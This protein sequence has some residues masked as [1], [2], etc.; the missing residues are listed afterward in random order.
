MSR[1][2]TLQTV[3]FAPPPPVE[4]PPLSFLPKT[5]SI[6]LAAYLRAVDRA[7]TVDPPAYTDH[8]LQLQIVGVADWTPEDFNAC[9]DRYNIYPTV[10]ADALADGLLRREIF[11][12]AGPVEMEMVR[13]QLYVNYPGD[14]G[15]GQQLVRLQ[16]LG[17][18][19]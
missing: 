12:W 15:M 7:G 5:P 3:T 11:G 8:D 17:R 9:A 18:W 14:L 19:R 6:L 1:S 4:T 2:Q 16:G 13:C 10:P